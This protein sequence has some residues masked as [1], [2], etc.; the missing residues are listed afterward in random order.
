M[1]VIV[2]DPPWGEYEQIDMA[3]PEFFGAMARAFDRVLDPRDGRFVTLVS[4][5][6]GETVEEAL[7]SNDLR[8]SSTHEVLVNGHPATVLI[9]GRA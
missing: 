1:D 5:K 3:L 6:A 4:R 2:T 8:I 9:G 7:I